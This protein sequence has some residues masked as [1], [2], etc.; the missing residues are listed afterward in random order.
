MH[1]FTKAALALAALPVAGLTLASP[2]SAHG[3][4]PHTVS[5]SGRVHIVDYDFGADTVC[6]RTFA[7]NDT[8]QLPSDSQVDLGGTANCD[9]IRVVVTA[10]GTLSDLG[11]VTISGTV[12]VLDRDCLVTDEMVVAPGTADGPGAAGRGRRSARRSRPR[13]RPRAPPRPCPGPRRRWP[14]APGRGSPSPLTPRSP[15]RGRR[16]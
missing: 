15:R 11:I 12:Q 6:D 7:D 14:A 9:E 1:R 4:L 10:A 2:A 8:A 13:P 3:N 16:R 5:L